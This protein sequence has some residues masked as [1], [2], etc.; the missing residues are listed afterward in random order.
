MIAVLCGADSWNDIEEYCVTKEEWLSE[1]LDLRNGIQSQDTFNR[2]ISGIDY[3]EFEK[4]FAKWTTGLMEKSRRREI[5]NLDGKTVRGAKTKVGKLLVHTVNAW[6]G[7]NK[8]SLGQV[9]T[10]ERSNE[11]V[12]IPEILDLLF[13]EK[14]IVTIATKKDSE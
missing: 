3:E 2:V 14:S 10:E 12:A 9:K 1:L 13:V 4:C 5:I 7:L 8:I 11:I 6:A